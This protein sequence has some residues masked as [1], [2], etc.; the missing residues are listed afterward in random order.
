[1]TN[2]KQV[3]DDRTFMKDPNSTALINIDVESIRIAKEAKR[4]RMEK[5]E[6]F[7]TL[8]SEVS[9]IKKLLLELNR[10]MGD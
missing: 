9:D 6:E 5:E 3:Y 8:K 7:E 4:R 2:L 1:M 10:K